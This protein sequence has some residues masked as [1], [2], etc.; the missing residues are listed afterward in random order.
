MIHGPERPCQLIANLGSVRLADLETIEA[1]AAD[2]GAGG[3]AN[4]PVN[5]TALLLGDLGNQGEPFVSVVLV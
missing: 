4:G 3:A 1:A 5:R 2:Q